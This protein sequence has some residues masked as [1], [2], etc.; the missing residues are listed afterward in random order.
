[1]NPVQEVFRGKMHIIRPLVYVEE[2]LL[3][4]YALEKKLPQLPRMCPMDGQTRRQHVK[5]IIAGLQEQEQNANIRE[6]IFRS[7]GHVNITFASP[8]ERSVGKNFS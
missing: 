1:M 7:L 6:N 2:E 8:Q 3:K 5:E 4:K